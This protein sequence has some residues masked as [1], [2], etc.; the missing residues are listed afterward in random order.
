MVN[1]HSSSSFADKG[2]VSEVSKITKSFISS[3]EESHKR[4]NKAVDYKLLSNLG[5]VPKPVLDLL[6]SSMAIPYA[7]YIPSYFLRTQVRN[8]VL[9]VSPP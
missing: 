5:F 2:A 8:L 4:N 9:S 3:L 6:A 1:S 7:S